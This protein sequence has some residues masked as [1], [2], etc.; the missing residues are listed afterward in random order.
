[1]KKCSILSCKSIGVSKTY[2]VTMKSD[3]HNYKIVDNNG[4]GV[5]TKNSH[6]AAYGLVSFQCAFLKYYYTLEYMSS[7]LTSE[8][9]SSKAKKKN[10]FT[11]KE[12]DAKLDVYLKHADRIGVVVLGGNIN[13]SGLS[14]N[15]ER[16]I[17]SITKKPF[18]YLRTPFNAIKGVGE[19]SVQN[20]IENQ[21]YNSL[22]EFV[23]KVDLKKV[24][25]KVFK[26]LLE[27][28]CMSEWAGSNAQI[29]DRYEKIKKEFAK[30]KNR[31]KREE[32]RAK[33][34][35][36]RLSVFEGNI[37][38]SFNADEKVVISDFPGLMK[39][40]DS[41][42]EFY[43]EFDDEEVAGNVFNFFDGLVST[44]K[45]VKVNP[46]DVFG[47]D[48]IDEIEGDGEGDG[49][50]DSEGNE[51]DADGVAKDG[52]LSEDEEN[53]DND[54]ENEGGYDEPVEYDDDVE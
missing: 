44:S 2:N 37:F 53:D 19:K 27:A 33:R 26:V 36:E 54:D 25:V 47:N 43:E 15:I 18:E 16:G 20:I 38:S 40:N 45:T 32:E 31:V 1:M 51:L 6:S 22:K 49:E 4:N 28:G 52:I 34:E 17:S 23:S 7:L 50:E 46:S 29:L 5:Y 8:L 9:G 14:F 39:S 24:N 3:Q 13:R 10:K 30:E 42:E 41:S 48:E 21:P 11:G 12:D 35:E